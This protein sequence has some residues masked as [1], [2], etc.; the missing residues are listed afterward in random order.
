MAFRVLVGTVFAFVL[1]GCSDMEKVPSIDPGVQR[2]SPAS[3]TNEHKSNNEHI[4]FLDMKRKAII[5]KGKPVDQYA[6]IV[7]TRKPDFN[8]NKTIFRSVS[9]WVK[10]QNLEATM[11]TQL[12]WS[13][14]AV[15]RIQQAFVNVPQPAAVSRELLAFMNDECQFAMEH[16]DGSFLDHLLFGYEYSAA[17]Y[18]EGSPRVLLLHSIMGGATNLFPIKVDQIERLKSF[19]DANEFMHI[20]A[21]PSVM[22][23][24]YHGKLLP[25]LL[26]AEDVMQLEEI[27]FHRVMAPH[28]DLKM[29]AEDFFVQLNYQLMHLLDFL[30]ASNW[31]D[32]KIMTDP[33]IK[34]FKA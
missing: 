6:D 14:R 32:P 9:N 18:K 22:R 30:P 8:L 11:N 3:G 7:V 19:L 12:Y 27:S 10:R 15:R 21:F 20:Q 13:D 24:L 2:N 31:N 26:A 16:T 33:S 29:S 4:A 1:Y 34:I 28:I 17:H 5:S 23:L 25:E